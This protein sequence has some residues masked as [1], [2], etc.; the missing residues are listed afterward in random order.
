MG[1]MSKAFG[2]MGGYIA[3][4]ADVIEYLKQRARPFLFSSAMTPANTAACIAAVEILENSDDLVRKLWKNTEYFKKEVSSLGFDI[5]KSQTP[6]TPVILGDAKLAREF[7]KML[8]EEKVF[9]QAIGYPTVPQGKARIRCMVSAIHEKEDLDF[10]IN[11]FEKV[12]KRL[13]I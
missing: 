12:K 6:I 7:S 2:V 13:K 4:N 5:G 10:A 11:A 1:T 3:S 9:A 8:F